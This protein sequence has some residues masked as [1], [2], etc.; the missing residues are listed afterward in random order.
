MDHTVEFLTGARILTCERRGA[1]LDL[2]TDKGRV[3]LGAHRAF[4]DLH[5]FGCGEERLVEIVETAGKQEAVCAVCGR[6]WKV[7]RA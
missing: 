5:C 6:S 4:T 3:I 1:C 2:M 7:D